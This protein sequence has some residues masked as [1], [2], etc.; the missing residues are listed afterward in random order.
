MKIQFQYPNY[1][2][3]VPR[4]F[5]YWRNGSLEDAFKNLGNQEM[6]TANSLIQQKRWNI[7]NGE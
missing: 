7:N 6:K 1:S 3:C 5:H 2:F 4:N